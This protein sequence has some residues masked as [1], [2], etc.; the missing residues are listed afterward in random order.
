MP[1]FT[2]LSQV[3]RIAV[4]ILMS[5]LVAPAHAAMHHISRV[6]NY[7]VSGPFDAYDGFIFS[8]SQTSVSVLPTIT[9]SAPG[10]PD[11]NWWDISG[12]QVT[13]YAGGSKQYYT[14]GSNAGYHCAYPWE[15]LSD[16]IMLIFPGDKNLQVFADISI[17]GPSV[18]PGFAFDLSF[19][20][21][22]GFTIAGVPEPSTWLMM[23]LGFCGFGFIARGK[24]TEARFV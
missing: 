14:C 1:A 18:Q 11:A 7:T 13:L 6:G 21:P 16:N 22:D 15:F 9:A 3:M 8:H 5:L 24:L 20:L 19:N 2:E 23:I 4:F 17:Y 10:A 12:Y